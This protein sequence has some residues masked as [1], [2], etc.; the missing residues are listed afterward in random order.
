MSDSKEKEETGKV[1]EDPSNKV[2]LKVENEDVGND[3][4]QGSML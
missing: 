2:E 4:D 1:E 3:D